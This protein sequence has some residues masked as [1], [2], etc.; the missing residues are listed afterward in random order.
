MGHTRAA[1]LR[2]L[3]DPCSTAE[4]AARLGISAPSA[5]E[6]AAALRRADL[7]QTERRGRSVRHSLTPLGHSLLRGHHLHGEGNLPTASRAEC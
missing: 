4:L 7:I 6:H 3:S 5:C 2:T 1:V